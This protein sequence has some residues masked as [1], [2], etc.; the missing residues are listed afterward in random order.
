MRPAAKLRLGGDCEDL[1]A[2]APTATVV[3]GT[4]LSQRP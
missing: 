2:N 1:Y 3:E 4:P